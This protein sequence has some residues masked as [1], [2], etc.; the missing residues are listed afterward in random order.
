[1]WKRHLILHKLV[2]LPV[3]WMSFSPSTLG[4]FLTP[5]IQHSPLQAPPNQD[6]NVVSVTHLKSVRQKMSLDSSYQPPLFI[7][8]PL[9]KQTS[10]SSHVY[11]L[12]LPIVYYKIQK[13]LVSTPTIPP[14]SALAM[15]RKSSLILNSSDFL[16]LSLVIFD[17]VNFIFPLG[18]LSSL[19]S[20]DTTVFLIL[21]TFFFFFQFFNLASRCYFIL[22]VQEMVIFNTILSIR[23][24]ALLHSRLKAKEGAGMGGKGPGQQKEVEVKNP[25]HTQQWPRG[26]PSVCG[27][28]EEA[29]CCKVKNKTAGV[30]LYPSRLRT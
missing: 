4:S 8:L 29:I 12:F 2:L 16:I 27:G 20:E 3:Y 13:H 25:L 1:M 28:T 17:P 18:R 9:Q 24:V 14:K 11:I 5:K 6:L 15:L 23:S 22:L 10:C 7:H 21:H 26:S 19:V 30:P